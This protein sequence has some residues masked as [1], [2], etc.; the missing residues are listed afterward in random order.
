VVSDLEDYTMKVQNMLQ[1]FI[2]SDRTWFFKSL[3]DFLGK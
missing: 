1:K 2:K 3:I